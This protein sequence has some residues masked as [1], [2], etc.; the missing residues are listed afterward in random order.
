[1]ARLLLTLVALLSSLAGL[2]SAKAYPCTLSQTAQILKLHNEADAN[3]HCADGLYITANRADLTAFCIDSTCLASMSSLA[4]ELP[5]YEVS[6]VNAKSLVDAA[7]AYCGVAIN[8]DAP[9]ATATSSSSS[10]SASSSSSSASGLQSTSSSTEQ[11]AVT[12]AM[13][14]LGAIVLVMVM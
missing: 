11:V 1:M 9:S 4:S 5:D 8:T 14:A 7:L 6:G 12:S 13:R 3:S 2:Q 10:P